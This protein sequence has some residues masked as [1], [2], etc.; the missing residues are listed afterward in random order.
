MTCD[1]LNS[2]DELLAFGF[3]SKE[4]H[5]KR[6]NILMNPED[7][8][9]ETN[10]EEIEITET[11]NKQEIKVHVNDFTFVK[12]RNTIAIPPEIRKYPKKKI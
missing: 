12:Y 10:I 3:I 11:E 2:L 9:F 8:S 1:E 7:F 4:E 5:T 6:C